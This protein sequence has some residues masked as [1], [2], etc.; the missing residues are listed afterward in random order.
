MSNLTELI[1]DCERKAAAATPGPWKYECERYSAKCVIGLKPEDDRWVGHFQPEFNGENNAKHTIQAVNSQ[2]KLIA[3]L[4]I[5]R[6]A[7]GQ[8]CLVKGCCKINDQ[9]Q[10]CACVAIRKMDKVCK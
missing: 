7:L 6:E 10:C 2:T 5:A 1:E 3:A 9:G 4:K 8:S